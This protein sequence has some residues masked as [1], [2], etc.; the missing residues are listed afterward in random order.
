[1]AKNVENKDSDPVK[2]LGGMLLMLF[3]LFL[4]G[5]SYGI[6]YFTHNQ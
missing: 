4:F 6:W 1:M 5:I 2:M 3:T